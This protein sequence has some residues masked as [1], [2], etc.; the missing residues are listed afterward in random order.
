MLKMFTSSP[1]AAMGMEIQ[2]RY[3]SKN[4]STQEETIFY[5]KQVAK[6][7][8]SDLYVEGKDGKF[9]Q[10]RIQ[11]GRDFIFCMDIP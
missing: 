3:S 10:R 11:L 2:N 6:K 7:Y 8:E 1:T 9:V 5:E 4:Y